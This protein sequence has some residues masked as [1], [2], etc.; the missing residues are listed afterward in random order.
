MQSQQNRKEICF[1]LDGST[2]LDWKRVIVEDPV[3]NRS[4]K[5][6]IFEWVTSNVYYRGPN[7]EKFNIYF[8]L[9]PQ[10]IWG[11]NGTW[12]QD[13]KNEPKTI[14]NLTGYQICYPLTSL[15]TKDN[16][17]DYERA[18]KEIFDRIWEKTLAAMK[19]FCVGED[20]NGEQHANLP[21]AAYSSYI[22]A[23]RKGKG[24]DWSA[25]IKPVYEYAKQVDEKTKKTIDGTI[26]ISKPQRTY[27]E[28][29]TYGEGDK[30]KNYTNVYGPGDRLVQPIKYMAFGDKFHKG[31]AHPVI[32]W[33]HIFWGSH[34]SKKTYGGSSKIVVSEMNFEPIS[35]NR[36][37]S[38]RMLPPNRAVDLDE[39]GSGSGH[40][41]DDNNN[42]HGFEREG[43]SDYQSPMGGDAGYDP[44]IFKKQSSPDSNVDSLLNANLVKEKEPE[45][46]E[47]EK[48]ATS[49]SSP[50]PSSTETPTTPNAKP[51][52]RVIKKN[53]DK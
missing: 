28:F 39:R 38:F 13:K 22:A 48:E 29:K 53:V 43:Y 14:H 37:P 32:A 34:S 30:L 45:P 6:S 26:D 27:I 15:E 25:A 7:E 33:T 17:S 35:D 16:P 31:I 3:V 21:A 10:Q 50:H 18:T 40:E 1:T 46:Q 36:G 23:E 11:I 5:D 49:K 44:N 24:K 51:K 8:E 2:P 12:D 41:G 20:G 4:K 47:K 19:K 9:C 42:S 52:A